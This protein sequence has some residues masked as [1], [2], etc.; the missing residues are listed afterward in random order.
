[1]NE[2]VVSNNQFGGQLPSIYARRIPGPPVTDQIQT[3]S[4]KDLEFNEDDLSYWRRFV[5]AQQILINKYITYIIIAI[6]NINLGLFQNSF[7]PLT[8]TINF[9]T[10]GSDDLTQTF[11]ET[12]LCDHDKDNL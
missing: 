10:R 7:N 3:N 2:E 6:K 5:N 12:K 4:G 8:S 9:M 1:M 11:Y